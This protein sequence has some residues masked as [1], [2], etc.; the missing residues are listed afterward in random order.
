MSKNSSNYSNNYQSLK[1]SNSQINKI[2]NRYY[3]TIDS[4][5]YNE[6]KIYLKPKFVYE[7][8]IPKPES[9]EI[10]TFTY[11]NDKNIINYKDNI[12]NKSNIIEQNAKNYLEY[13]RKFINKKRSPIPSPFLVYKELTSYSPIPN[14]S[15]KLYNNSINLNSPNFIN[16]NNDNNNDNLNKEKYKSLTT[17]LS[18]SAISF[19]DRKN[20]ITNPG[21][22]YN[23]R[24]IDFYKYRAEQKKYLEANYE[25]MS[26]RKKIH[27]KKEPEVNP[28][29]PKNEAYFEHSK[30]DLAHNPILNPVNYYSYNKY[31]ERDLKT[32]NY[33]NNFNRINNSIDLN[34]I[35][36]NYDNERYRS[37][38]Q[39]AGNELIN[40]Q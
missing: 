16:Q 7:N 33:N 37:S 13:M 3:N 8:F 1:K 6:N 15:T 19:N 21:L 14:N 17:S 28:Y 2:S 9:E 34:N 23:R 25:L 36:I 5:H 18:S 40:S 38:L 32:K 4:N 26:Y 27:D 35:Y 31:L 39:Q 30:S 20:E 11:E 24:N 29:N 10:P 22:F 12:Y